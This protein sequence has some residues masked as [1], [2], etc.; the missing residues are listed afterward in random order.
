MRTTITIALMLALATLFIAC[1]PA[2]QSGPQGQPTDLD[3]AQESGTDPDPAPTPTSTPEP[4]KYPNL[5]TFLQGLVTKYEAKELTEIAAAAQAHV[6]D[7]ER[8][9]VD[10]DFSTDPAAVAQFRADEQLPVHWPYIDALEWW[11]NDMDR[12]HMV[13]R[14]LYYHEPFMYAY[15]PVSRLGAL[16]QREGVTLV[17]ALEDTDGAFAASQGASG[18]RS[19]TDSG[20]AANRVFVPAAAEEKGIWNE[21]DNILGPLMYRYER[22]ELTAE[23]VVAA[24]KSGDTPSFYQGTSIYVGLRLLGRT[25]AETNAIAAWLKERGVTP[26][27]VYTSETLGGLI[28]TYLPVNLVMDLKRMDRGIWIQDQRAGEFSEQG[29][30]PQNSRPRTPDGQ[31]TG[32]TPTQGGTAHGATAWN[33]STP[34]DG[35]NGGGIRVGII[36]IG[37]DGFNA[38]MGSDLPPSYLVKRHCYV[39]TKNAAGAVTRI[40]TTG[41]SGLDDC[42]GGPHGT[43]VAEAVGDIAPHALLYISN[44]GVQSSSQTARSRIRDAVNWMIRENVQVINYSMNWT[45]KE[46]TGD[47]VPRVMDNDLLNIIDDAVNAGI[48]WVSAAGNDH[49]RIW[50]GNLSGAVDSF[51][52]KYVDFATSD[53]R[54]YITFEGTGRDCGGRTAVGRQL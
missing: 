36:D 44:A 50:Y 9:L 25:P 48:L 4:P 19:G 1:G 41:T 8:V 32:T 27:R 40:S 23:Q 43:A 34:M 46:N 26:E 29:P 24:Y 52:A 3:V 10:I 54:N 28:L 13:H 5:D 14:P 16:S 37:F 20:S 11:L 2:S 35:I 18:T 22:G 53:N 31:T 38:L 21:F 17:R 42:D 6:Y 30:R 39:V 49:Q 33:A 15:V 12:G 51:G 45:F 47:G 7:A